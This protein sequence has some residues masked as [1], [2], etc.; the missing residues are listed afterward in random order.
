MGIPFQG[1]FFCRRQLGKE[2]SKSTSPLSGGL[3]GSVC[4]PIPSLSSHAQNIQWIPMM[5]F[6]MNSYGYMDVNGLEPITWNCWGATWCRGTNIRILA[7]VW[8]LH[9]KSVCNG[10]PKLTCLEFALRCWMLQEKHQQTPPQKK[11]PSYVHLAS[12]WKFST[13]PFH[14]SPANPEVGCGVEWCKSMEAT[15]GDMVTMWWVKSPLGGD[16]GD[17]YRFH[18]IKV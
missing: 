12:S 13:K 6:N 11:H 17:W 2:G 9:S 7:I 18:L 8:H 1:P 3:G 5:I 10:F 15:A 4:F 16:S 14:Q